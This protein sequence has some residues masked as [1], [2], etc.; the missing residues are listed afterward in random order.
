VAGG[1][2]SPFFYANN[3]YI[4]ENKKI[5]IEFINL[6]N[7]YQKKSNFSDVDLK[8]FINDNKDNL[9]EEYINFSYFKITPENLTG[10]NEFN[11]IFYKK[12]DEIDNDI[13]KGVEISELS[14]KLKI[15][16]TIKKK[17]IFNKNNDE[18]H[19]K[20]Y[21]KRNENK[22]QLIDENNFYVLFQ[23]NN[24]DKILPTLDDLNFKD[25]I[26]NTLYLQKKNE[27]NKK[28]IDKINDKKFNNTIFKE[29]SNGKIENIELQSIKDDDKFV[30]NS[31]KLLYA[32]PLGS[33]ALVT[34]KKNNIYLVK[35]SKINIS[36][37]FRNSDLI[38]EYLNRSNQK[39]KNHL[40][41]SFDLLIE[42]KYEINVNQKTLERV[43]NFFR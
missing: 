12:I 23:I 8:L 33:Y 15:K 38:I 22:I 43:K 28:I 20:I 5:E 7:K 26:I 6:E 3:T 21:Q 35:L 18:I 10:S 39:V 30:I 34:D 19:N 37:L 42:E 2:K 41:E 27:Y 9:K 13:S 24:I 14:K 32:L 29:I 11:E 25:K 36:N 16:P 31:I 4:E 40:F 17:Y 1:I